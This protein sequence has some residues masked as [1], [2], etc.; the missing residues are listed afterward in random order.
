MNQVFE[1]T[2]LNLEKGEV[3][4]W[5]Y[6]NDLEEA[7]EY[8]KEMCKETPVRVQISIVNAEYEQIIDDLFRDTPAKQEPSEDVKLII[9]TLKKKL[10][11][12]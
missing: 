4:E 7:S 6:F 2:L 5:C 1:V 9:E 11:N 10:E 8:A 3:F 12:G